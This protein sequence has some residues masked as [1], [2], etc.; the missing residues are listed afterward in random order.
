MWQSLWQAPPG[1][2][3]CRP[4]PVVRWLGP[5]P[6][7]H[8]SGWAPLPVCLQHRGAL[9]G[10]RWLPLRAGERRYSPDCSAK[11]LSAPG[12]DHEV[13]RLRG[14]VCMGMGMCRASLCPGRPGSAVAL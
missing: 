2:K 10:L 5:D 9:W 11:G 14:H 3:T 8:V 6:V 12:Q 7:H 1:L 4:R 13:R